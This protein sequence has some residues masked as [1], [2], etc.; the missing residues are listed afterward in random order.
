MGK[1]LNVSPSVGGNGGDFVGIGTISTGNDL[2]VGTQWADVVRNILGGG[3]PSLVHTESYGI[4]DILSEVSVIV[5]AGCYV[6]NKADG[7][8]IVTVE[9]PYGAGGAEIMLL[10]VPSLDYVVPTGYV[11]TGYSNVYLRSLLFPN[12][13]TLTLD[14]TT[15]DIAPVSGSEGSIAI[16]SNQTTFAVSLEDSTWLSSSITGNILKLTSTSDALVDR[17]QTITVTAGVGSNIATA[18]VEVT[19][20]A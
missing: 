15:V 6:S 5:S 19:Q 7:S 20:T 13:A 12:V 3:V 4:G 17:S 14:P 10:F 2:V 9:N 18:T 11:Y 8:T 1:E 16:T